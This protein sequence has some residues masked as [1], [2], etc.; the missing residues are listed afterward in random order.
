MN[1]SHILTA[2]NRDIHSAIDDL[3]E[4]TRSAI[5][6]GWQPVGN[7]AVVYKPG[8]VDAEG[9]YLLQRVEQ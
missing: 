2:S 9:W 6:N 7:V 1:F 3:E 5:E 8:H 4:Q